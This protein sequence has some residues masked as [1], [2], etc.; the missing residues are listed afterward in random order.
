MDSQSPLSA[1]RQLQG[2]GDQQM[3]QVRHGVLLQVEYYLPHYHCALA[4]KYAGSRASL[5]TGRC[6]R[7]CA[8]AP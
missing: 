3:C 8:A 1:V 4:A 7:G 2:C 6:T 5:R